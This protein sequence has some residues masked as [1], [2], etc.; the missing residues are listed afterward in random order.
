MWQVA[1]KSGVSELASGGPVSL[2]ARAEVS[3]EQNLRIACLSL[4]LHIWWVFAGIYA[5][6]QDTLALTF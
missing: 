2:R 3:D 4:K 5:L 1:A 6:F